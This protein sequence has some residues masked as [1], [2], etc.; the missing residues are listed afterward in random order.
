MRRLVFIYDDQTELDNFG[1]IVKGEYDYTAVHWPAESEKLFRGRAPNI[2]V[3]DLYLAPA[4]G[5]RLPTPS[6]RNTAAKAARRVA[7]HFSGHTRTDPSMT[8]PAY[9]KQ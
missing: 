7:E 1:D 5:D 8:K 4:S 9:K 3:S 2:F 6:Q